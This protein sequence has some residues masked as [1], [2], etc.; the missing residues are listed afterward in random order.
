[1]GRAGS[2]DRWVVE[3]LLVSHHRIEDGEQLAHA[4][5]NGYFLLF[6]AFDELVI[7]RFEDGIVTNASEGSHI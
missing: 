5:S 1:M 3:R 6:A 2:N 4:G 7:L